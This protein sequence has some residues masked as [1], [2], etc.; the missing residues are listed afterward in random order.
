MSDNSHIELGHGAGGRAMRSLIR[1]TIAPLLDNPHL[2]PLRDG[3]VLG[4]ASSDIVF[5]TD[6][7]VVH[8]VEFPGGDLGKLAICGT[9]NDL[10]VMGA[11]P[12]YLSLAFILEEGLP[13]E[14]F[15]RLLNSAAQTAR[16][17]GVQI[18]TGDTKVVPRGQCDLMFVNTSGIGLY[19]LGH[20]LCSAPVVAGDAIIVTGSLGDHAVAI[21]NARDGISLDI[22]TLSDCAA[23]TG[24]IGSV[25][26]KHGGVKWM[27]DPTRG[28]AAA[29]LSELT[30]EFPLGVIIDEAA[31]PVAS[32]TMAVC[33][34][35]GYEPLHLANE[36]KVIMVVERESA[37]VV[38]DTLRRHPQGVQAARIGTLTS[39]M[40]RMVRVRTAAG[41]M[42]R[43]QR[44]A[45]EL[46]PRI[47]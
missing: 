5:T 20:G 29:V 25:L 8:P 44:P 18:V 9:V 22:P 37:D 26:T 28:G 17:A 27:R 45:G 1:D 7:Y 30:E 35:L 13:L 34:L 32:A 39:D 11:E 3:A 21:L 24:L 15:A 4:L 33:E 14:L 38:L 2:S 23:L 41:G 40:P 31:V 10:L 46:L 36:G 6:S 19:P 47:C 12:R 16:E 42:R 43:L